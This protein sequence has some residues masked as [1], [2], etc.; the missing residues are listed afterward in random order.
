MKKWPKVRWVEQCMREGMQIES[1]SIPVDEK[2]RLLDT[3]S[4]T[5]LKRIVVGS[6]VHPKWTP[7]MAMVEEIVA[8]FHP[9]PGVI[10]TAIFMGSQGLPRYLKCCPPLT[11]PERTRNTT[12][13]TV[14]DIFTRRNANSPQSK[15]IGRWPQIIKVAK[16]RGVKESNIGVIAPFGSN[17]V[18][19]ISQGHAMDLLQRQWKMWSDADINVT[20]IT[21]SDP[22]GWNMPDQ[23]YQYILEV[24]KR[25]P[26]IH[27][28]RF[29]L[30]NTRGV[31]LVS[32][33]VIL[34]TLGPEDSIELDGSLGGLAGCPYCGNGRSA[35]M[36]PTEDFFYMTQEMGI[37]E[38]E[39]AGVDLYKLCDAVAVAEE[40]IG[41]PTWGH[42]SKSGPKPRGDRLYPMDMPFIETLEQAQHFRKGPSVFQGCLS[43]W[44]E[45]IKSAQRDYAEWNYG[46]FKSI[47]E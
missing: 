8:K 1:A 43:P 9:K 11:P 31:A 46:R 33:Y 24:R 42:V 3:I 21:F 14:C 40:V 7:Q 26:E 20:G 36:V 38:G 5:G 35:T 47:S 2:V 4:E 41:H 17:W 29:H 30:H 23:I 12:T 44:T 16:E 34:T 18:G 39:L 45:P 37:T 32:F 19:D 27:N 10:Y 22:M 13:C 6:F 28:W 25:W 15:E